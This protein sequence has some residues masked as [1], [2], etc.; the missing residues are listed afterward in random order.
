[1]SRQLRD[2]HGRVID[3]LRLSLTDRCNFRCIYCMPPQ[4]QE[5][6]P[7]ADILSYEEMLRLAAIFAGL[8]VTRFKIT[9]GEPLC[10]KG[11]VDFIRRVK[12]LS[13]AT[14]V[15]LTSNGTLLAPHL[16]DLAAMG[17]DGINVS[18]DTLSPDHY[19]RITRSKIP[20]GAVLPVMARARELGI[21]VKINVV[22]LKG[23]NEDDLPELARYALENGYHIRFIELMPVGPG[24]THE[25]VGQDDIRAMVESAFGPLRPLKLRI[26]N[27]P[28][29]HFKVGDYPGSVGFISA[30]SKKFCRSCNR[31]RLTAA[32]YL[33]SCLHHDIGV[34]LQPLLR[35]GA[36][37]E[38]LVAAIEGA[39][40]R[41]PAAH[42][43]EPGL[44]PEK[45]FLMNTV[46][47]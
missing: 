26:G 25:G 12:D 21:R 13:E 1:M 44:S 28:A 8:G 11:A 46:G 3:Y 15:S 33:K 31:V 29:E 10:R 24:I 39:V 20:L 43:L 14:E 36:D 2:M 34:D 35:K 7:H 45:T 41:K 32:G 6:I 30:L 5:H 18:L 9:G 42:M 38:A 22:P 4:G 16:D 47:G 23:Y 37:D 40:R 27:G 19:G 17:I